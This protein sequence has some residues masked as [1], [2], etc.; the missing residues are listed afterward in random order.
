MGH[1]NIRPKVRR[2]KV[3]VLA[4]YSKKYSVNNCTIPIPDKDK[5]IEISCPWN[6]KR[7]LTGTEESSV[8][9]ANKWYKG[10]REKAYAA[11][12]KYKYKGK[13]KPWYMLDTRK[14]FHY[15]ERKEKWG[16]RVDFFRVPSEAATMY[17][18][19]VFRPNNGRAWFM[20]QIVQHKLAKWEK[21]NPRPVKPGQ[22][23]PDMFEEEY[24]VPW[25]A[26][27]D[28]AEEHFRDF[29]VSMYDKLPLT[30][31]FQKP[32]NQFS[33]EPVAEIKDV[34]MEGHK[35]NELDPKKSKLLKTAQKKTNEVKAKRTN[36][37]CTNLKDHRRKKGRIILPDAA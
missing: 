30:G 5:L 14:T 6:E 31:R 29:V 18:K 16:T 12:G 21:K 23:P 1:S 24:V 35:V 32:D 37:I 4:A 3:A 11:S 27:R 9:N 7:T 2:R 33:E 22:N 25:K 36:L 26:K 19:T 28:A 15:E 20:E 8:W 13:R 34:N 17:N 10:Q